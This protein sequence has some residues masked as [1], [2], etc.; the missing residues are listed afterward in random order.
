MPRRLATVLVVSALVFFLA[1]G[2]SAAPPADATD[3]CG[4]SCTFLVSAVKAPVMALKEIVVLE[5]RFRTEGFPSLL[6][7]GVEL[8]ARSF[9]VLDALGRAGL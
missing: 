5:V 1:I 3:R 9:R 8:L 7:A 6:T 2:S 4:T